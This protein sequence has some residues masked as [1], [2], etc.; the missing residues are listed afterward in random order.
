MRSIY[1]VGSLRSPLIRGIA[2]ALRRDGHE[3][4]DDWHSAGPKADDI[5]RGYEKERGRT[6]PE[7]LLGAHAQDIM[8]FDRHNI[9]TRNTTILALPAGRSGHLEL[10]LAI[11]AGK[12]THILLDR[13]YDRW[14]IMYGLAGHVWTSLLDLR[15]Y[16]KG[17]PLL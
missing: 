3:V 6:L 7:A 2:G 17:N 13:D 16:L 10:G 15:A 11:G 4:F 12:D 14:D 5:W 9:L 1:I 8:A